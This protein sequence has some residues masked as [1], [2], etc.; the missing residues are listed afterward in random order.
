MKIYTKT[1]D[2]GETALLGGKR[3]PKH[4]LR[5][6]A[7]GALDETNAALGMALS[8]FPK[9]RSWKKLR[10]SMENVQHDLFRAGAVLATPP[11]RTFKNAPSI[12]TA[13]TARLERAIDAMETKLPPLRQFILPG[14]S[15]SSA[16]L[17][18]ARVVARRAERRVT[19]LSA[20]EHV[21]SEILVYLN[22]LSDFLFVAAREANRLAN[23]PDVPW[24]K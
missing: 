2:R 10:A 17:H 22:R 4:G 14:G 9:K 12:T 18:Y 7:Y 1:G 23:V 11:D 24:K 3:I 5:I 19:A 13:H 6:E 21:P 20:R 16:S 15:P 8:L